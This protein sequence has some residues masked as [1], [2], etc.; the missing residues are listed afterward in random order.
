MKTKAAGR[1]RREPVKNHPTLRSA[2]G[3]VMLI[4]TTGSRHEANIIAGELVSDGLVVC[5]NVVQVESTYKWKGNVERAGE[6][7]LLCKT[8]AGLA[9]K[10]AGRIKGFH[11]YEVPEIITVPI[12]KGGATYL[13]W[14]DEALARE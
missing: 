1:G 4:T 10:V 14:M 2:D 5:V 9:E 3:F 11:S 8:R 7:M 12:Q 13:E 6:F